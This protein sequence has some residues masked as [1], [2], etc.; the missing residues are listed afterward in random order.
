MSKF[1]SPL[2]NI[3]VA[4]P[5]AQ[6]WNE[7]I[8]DE[9]ARFCGACKLNVYNLSG[10]SRRESENLIFQSEGNRLCVRFYRRADGTILTKDC[11]VGWRAIRRN[12]SKTA[13]AFASL[14]FTALGAIG[15]TNF[16]AKSNQA[17]MGAMT[18][19]E[20]SNVSVKEKPFAAMGNFAIEQK[21]EIEAVVGQLAETNELHET[22]QKVHKKTKRKLIQR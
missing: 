3:R 11:P 14:I 22:P 1:T 5:C 9:R 12:V 2:E 20:N 6:D 7:M 4:S 17:T 16:F 19:I 18:V 15:L 10:M 21:G 13:A 8:G